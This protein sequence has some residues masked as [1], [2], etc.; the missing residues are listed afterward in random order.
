MEDLCGSSRVQCCASMINLPPHIGALM[1]LDALCAR[2]VKRMILMSHLQSM[3]GM[4][5]DGNRLRKVGARLLFRISL[6]P[7]PQ[8]RWP[9]GSYLQKLGCTWFLNPLSSFIVEIGFP[10]NLVPLFCKDSPMETIK[11]NMNTHAEPNGDAWHGESQVMSPDPASGQVQEEDTTAWDGDHL[12][13]DGC[14]DWNMEHSF[15]GHDRSWYG[16]ESCYPATEWWEESLSE[17]HEVPNDFSRDDSDAEYWE[18][19]RTAKTLI[20][21]ETSDGES[22]EDPLLE[23]DPKYIGDETKAEAPIE[24]EW[25]TG[26]QAEQDQSGCTEGLSDD[27]TAELQALLD[28]EDPDNVKDQ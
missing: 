2:R 15:E 8:M 17:P 6:N 24:T 4:A 25:D 3:G 11:G 9:I 7:H 22:L 12:P 19:M 18:K 23:I 26:H 16:S 14:G 5:L 10:L 21:G 20:L 1:V 27:F 28:A 13:W